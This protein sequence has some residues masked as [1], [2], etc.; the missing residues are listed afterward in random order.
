MR[1]ILVIGLGKFGRELIDSLSKAET[2]IIAVDQN[3]SLVN[4]VKDVV[5]YSAQLDSTDIAALRE[6][7]AETVDIAI[8]TIGENFE[9]CIL[10]VA[11]LRELGVKSII[12]RAK[13][14]REARILSIV[15]A[16]QVIEVEKEVARRL[17]RTLFAPSIKDYIALAEGYSIL[18]WEVS[19]KFIGKSL[20]N[21]RFR[22]DYGVNVVGIRRNVPQ[23]IGAEK[24][25][26][27]FELVP[28][29]SYVFEKGDILLI[30]GRE[31]NLTKLTGIDLSQMRE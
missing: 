2:E 11:V 6:I 21:C 5:S 30:V 24:S 1:K 9:S 22:A 17:A 25:D 19:E 28:D 3:L 13:N 14:D 12:V 29:A 31:E 23:D 10:T 20:A 27:T 8:V 4:E 7:G 16:T 26:T 15:G 18:Q